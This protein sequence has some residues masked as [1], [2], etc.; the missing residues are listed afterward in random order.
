MKFSLEQIEDKIEF[1]EATSLQTLEKRIQDK[2]DHN[3]AI[4]LAVHH[5][6]HQAVLEP[7]TGQPYYTAVVHFKNKKG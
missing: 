6:S 4:L 1:F 3:R 2:V 7:K 5:V